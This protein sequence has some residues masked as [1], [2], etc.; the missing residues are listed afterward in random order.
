MVALVLV[1]GAHVGLV[2]PLAKSAGGAAPS[3]LRAPVAR[4]A[5]GNYD[6]QSETRDDRQ[7]VLAEYDAFRR[8]LLM[9]KTRTVLTEED[10]RDIE[11]RAGLGTGETL[12]DRIARL[13]A[14]PETDLPQEA[15]DPRISLVSGMQKQKE[16]TD[17]DAGY[18]R[19]PWWQQKDNYS[20]AQRKDRRTVFMHDDWVRH[21]SSERFVRN[22]LTLPS[23]GISQSLGKEL[24][25]VSSSAA[26]VVLFNM[27]R[28][29]RPFQPASL[30]SQPP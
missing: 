11:S 1:A 14:M 19:V 15:K 25:F 9:E 4:M 8:S 27:V 28:R 30:A 17:K 24:T 12:G 21:R 29:A 3:L 22:L 16:L 2:R 10:I 23:S 18:E 13:Q 20:E 5:E 26:F 7:S 6:R